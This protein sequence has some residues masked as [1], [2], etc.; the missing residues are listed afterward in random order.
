VLTVSHRQY[1][2]RRR[3]QAAAALGLLL[4]YALHAP[5]AIYRWQDD[6][7]TT[8]YGDTPPP[9]VHAPQ[10]LHPTSYD[11]YGRVARVLDGDTVVLE[12]ERRVRLLGIDTPEIAH[13][14]R[15]GEKLGEKARRFLQSRVAGKRIRLRYDLQHRDRYGR[16]LAH[17][18][19]ED[20]SNINAQL[21]EQGLAH[22]LFKWPNLKHAETYYA[23]EQ[24][25]RRQ[26]RGIWALAAYRVRPMQGLAALR[27]RF[28]RLRGKVTR[29]EKKRRY[30]YL[31]FGDQL[32]VAIDNKRQPLFEEAGILVET[33][34]GQTL[35]LRGWLSRRRGT[36]F[37]EL[38]HPF[39]LERI[40]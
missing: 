3:R 14:G 11:S 16:L 13:R 22:A 21:L 6:T 32:Q 35:T 1:G 26:E 30:R 18:H 40:E 9:N 12:D 29:V 23:L 4:G 8:H 34:R 19:L 25:A 2:K 17:L 10:Q 15:P 5:A 33:L 39:Q 37:L 38:E 27:N 7:G 24:Q 20:G 31:L 28:V 36:P